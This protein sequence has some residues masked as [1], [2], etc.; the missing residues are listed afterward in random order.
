MEEVVETLESIGIEPIMVEV[1]ARC[2]DWS[3]RL[4]L[5]QR[6]GGEPPRNYREFLDVV[7]QLQ[8]AKAGD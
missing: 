1:I 3:A 2:M 7:M 5:K 6:F 8:T 4:G